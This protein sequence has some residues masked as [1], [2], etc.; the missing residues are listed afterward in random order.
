MNTP[1]RQPSLLSRSLRGSLAL[2]CVATLLVGSTANAGTILQFT[3]VN[4][5]DIFTATNSGGGV[6]TLS[7]AGNV[8]GGGL[9]IPVTASNYWECPSRWAC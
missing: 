9:S 5:A 4:S 8:D 3:Q 6:T 1:V 2:A 7:T